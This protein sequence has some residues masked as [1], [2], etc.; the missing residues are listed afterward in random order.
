MITVDTENM[1]SGIR[2]YRNLRI[3][4]KQILKTVQRFKK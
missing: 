3:E 2:T 4:I 1:G